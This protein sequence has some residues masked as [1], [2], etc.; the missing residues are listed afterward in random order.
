MKKNN[1]FSRVFL[2][3]MLSIV[4]TAFNSCSDDYKEGTMNEAKLVNDIKINISNSFKLASGM[5]FQ[6]IYSVIPEDATDQLLIWK[7]SNENVATVTQNGYIQTKGLGETYISVTPSTTY[8]AVK[9]I[10]LTVV[11]KATSIGVDEI[12]MFEGTSLTLTG[13][14]SVLPENGYKE[15]LNCTV[16]DPSVVSYENGTL[17]ALKAGTTTITVKTVDG[18]NLTTTTTVTVHTA[19]PV[20]NIEI[21]PNQEFAITD[22]NMLLDFTLTP[23][24]A[25]VETLIWEST[26][27]S[28]ATV[29]SEGR[30]TAH[31]YGSVDIKAIAPDGSKEVKATIHINKG[32]INDIGDVLSIYGF[33]NSATGAV[34]GDKLVVTYAD[35]QRRADLLRGTAYLDVDK[36]PVLGIKAS[37][38]DMTKLWHNLDTKVDGGTNGGINMVWGNVLPTNDGARVYYIDLA[39][40]KFGGNTLQGLGPQ[41]MSLFTFKTG[42]DRA[43][44]YESGYNLYWVKTFKSMQELKD[45]IDNE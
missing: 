41:K 28:I 11:P 5:D 1:I 26:D 45:F 19:I 8:E 20:E 35:G 33:T 12:E 4:T 21:A 37:C 7:S 43:V 3:G 6:A 44:G 18:S 29:N 38:L 13:Y 39:A 25:T 14:V 22:N 40:V 36:Y 9:T 2:W 10:F 23:D 24:N 34:Q 42:T 16:S 32:K 31:N 17:K 30:I 15:E 27:E